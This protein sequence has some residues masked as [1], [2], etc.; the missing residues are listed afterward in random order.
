MA[1]EQGVV[2]QT[3]SHETPV[4]HSLVEQAIST[5][6]AMTQK[7]YNDDKLAN[8]WRWSICG[9]ILVHGTS[10]CGYFEG[11]K[12]SETVNL[13][14]TPG[15]TKKNWHC[16]C[17]IKPNNLNYHLSYLFA[18]EV[19]KKKIHVVAKMEDRS[20]S[21]QWEDFAESIRKISPFDKYKIPVGKNMKARLHKMLED[22]ERRK[23]MSHITYTPYDKLMLEL[24]ADVSKKR[25]DK[26]KKTS[27]KR[28]PESPIREDGTPAPVAYKALFRPETRPF[29]TL[30]SARM[31][32][33]AANAEASK[34]DYCAAICVV[35]N[36]ANLMY[37]EKMDNV[38]LGRVQESQN[39][40][41]ESARKN[42]SVKTMD[43]SAEGVPGAVPIM[44]Q[45]YC[46]GAVAV[47]GHDVDMDRM[48]ATSALSVIH[49]ARQ[50][51]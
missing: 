39:R 42:V 19:K 46:L 16:E 9:G 2:Q 12:Y 45:G 38:E 4:P 17:L 50:G 20:P 51:H 41:V 10:K 30:E 8:P 32:A 13:C 33:A 6:Q 1:V 36:S 27:K 24:S 7:Q 44:W 43:T 48:V 11:K 47:A 40:A 15:E 22:I 28:K 3:L 37:F 26:L 34:R 18:M 14:T 25:E 29:L 49:E 35:D 31:V 23:V 5:Q 21:D